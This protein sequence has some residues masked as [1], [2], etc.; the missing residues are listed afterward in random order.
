[1]GGLGLVCPGTPNMNVPTKFETTPLIR[2]SGKRG[3]YTTNQKHENDINSQERDP[4]LIMPVE[5]INQ[6]WCQSPEFCAQKCRVTLWSIWWTVWPNQKPWSD[7][8]DR[9]TYRTIPLFPSNQLAED[10]IVCARNISPHGPS[11]S[12]LVVIAIQFVLKYAF[13]SK[14]SSLSSDHAISI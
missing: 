10:N 8:R 7:H 1:M 14:I 11:C 3:N 9:L 12:W 6:V 5:Y 13:S 2:S 4:K